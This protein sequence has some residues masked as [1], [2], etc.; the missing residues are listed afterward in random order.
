MIILRVY[1]LWWWLRYR[2]RSSISGGGFIE[3]EVTIRWEGPDHSGSASADITTM[4]RYMPRLMYHVVKHETI[5]VDSE[6]IWKR[7]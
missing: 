1:Q 7:I 2:I 3:P 5:R 6:Y 4:I